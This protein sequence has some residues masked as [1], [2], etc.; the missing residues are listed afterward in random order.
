[1]NTYCTNSAFDEDSPNKCSAYLNMQRL[2]DTLNVKCVGKKNCQLVKL[3]RFIDK[4]VDAAVDDPCFHEDALMFIQ[5]GCTL[6]NNE[7]VDRK[8]RALVLGCAAVFIALFVINY[9]DYIK[10]SQENNYVEWDVKTITAGDY[11]IEF[12]LD[13]TFYPDWIEKEMPN[14]LEQEAARGHS[15]ATKAKA[16]SA[17]IQHEMETRLD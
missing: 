6:S 17:W 7:L 11:T 2:T 16:F 3:N 4:P 15:Y 12:D 5:V 8:S 13:P 1:M 10:K 14:W 9:L